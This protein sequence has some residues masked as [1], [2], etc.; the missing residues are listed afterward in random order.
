MFSGLIVLNCCSTIASATVSV[1]SLCALLIAAPINTPFGIRSLSA[2][3]AAGTSITSNRARIR[4]VGVPSG[5]DEV[6]A[7]LVQVDVH[8]PFERA[9]DRIEEQQADGEEE[10]Q[11]RADAHDQ[12]DAE[13]RALGLV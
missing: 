2:G 3:P 7:A 12:A 9:V 1:P 5:G 11:R 4:I 8:L 10:E 6:L 13:Q